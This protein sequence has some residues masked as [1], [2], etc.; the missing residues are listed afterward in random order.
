SHAF[1]QVLDPLPAQ[2]PAG[3]LVAGGRIT[4]ANKG[5]LAARW[6]IGFGAGQSRASAAVAL[7]TPG[8]GT[9][10]D[11]SVSKAYAGGAGLGGAD[12]V[13]MDDLMEQLGTAAA[14]SIVAWNRTGRVQ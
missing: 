11:F 1:Q 4:E 6:I 8:T 14:D 10:A 7:S 13:D 9:L 12:F 5:S 3:T 2:V